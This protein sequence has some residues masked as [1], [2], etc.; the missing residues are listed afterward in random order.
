MLI[1]QAMSEPLDGQKVPEE[2]ARADLA[3]N[4]KLAKTSIDHR[5]EAS[6]FCKRPMRG[7]SRRAIDAGRGPAW[8]AA[9][10]C[11]ICGSIYTVG[12]CLGRPL[13]N[14]IDAPIVPTIVPGIISMIGSVKTSASPP[15]F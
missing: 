10:L 1:D 5:R 11:L 15:L 12:G 13:T 2:L 9:N 8:V 6:K 4:L 14:A 3:S 7:A